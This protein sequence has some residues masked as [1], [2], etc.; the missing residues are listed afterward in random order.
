MA[1]SNTASGQP[2]TPTIKRLYANSGNR[3]AF[4]DCMSLLVDESGAVISTICHIK[5]N[6]PGSARYD[7]DQID[8]DR[9]HYRNLIL[10]CA[11]HG[12]VIDHKPNESPLQRRSACRLEGCSRELGYSRSDLR[13]NRRC[14]LATACWHP[15]AVDRRHGQ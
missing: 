7:P 1:G 8:E 14:N 13:R 5:G 11:N 15:R 12:R 3:C 6:N 2:S 9:Q 10:L 4:P